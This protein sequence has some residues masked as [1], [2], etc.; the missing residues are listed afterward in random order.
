MVV[1]AAAASERQIRYAAWQKGVRSSAL[2]V[3]VSAAD[4]PYVM[5]PVREPGPLKVWAG[6]I[7]FF[8]T[9]TAIG[10][11]AAFHII[12]RGGSVFEAIMTGA[13]AG[14]AN[15]WLLFV[16]VGKTIEHVRRPPR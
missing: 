16:V 5:P 10:L 11:L 13:C 7:L 4:R 3:A 6:V 12:D 2:A 14:G 15:A 1:G 9:G 8:G